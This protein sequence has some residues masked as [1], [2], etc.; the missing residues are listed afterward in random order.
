L[1]LYPAGDLA[2]L[3]ISEVSSD[4]NDYIVNPPNSNATYREEEKQSSSNFSN[5]ETMNCRQQDQEQNN[6]Q[7]GLVAF[8]LIWIRYL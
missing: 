6:W 4:G 8:T 1:N 3:L 7:N 2:P 5:I